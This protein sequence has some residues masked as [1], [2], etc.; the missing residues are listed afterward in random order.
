MNQRLSILAPRKSSAP[1]G[2]ALSTPLAK[3][4]I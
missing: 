4:D 3:N 2:G 1:L